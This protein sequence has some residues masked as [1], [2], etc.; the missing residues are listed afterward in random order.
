MSRVVVVFKQSP[1]LLWVRAAGSTPNRATRRSRSDRLPPQ[2]STARQRRNVPAALYRTHLLS[3]EGT[4]IRRLLCTCT[5]SK[6]RSSNT[7]QGDGCNDS[8]RVPLSPSRSRH[9]LRGGLSFSHGSRDLNPPNESL[10]FVFFPFLFSCLYLAPWHTHRFIMR[11]HFILARLIKFET[12]STAISRSYK[13][14]ALDRWEP[15]ALKPPI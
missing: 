12:T 13:R 11:L 14:I 9:V 5:R 8:C 1:W 6:F 10:L 15:V 3:I 2:L 7:R 4:W